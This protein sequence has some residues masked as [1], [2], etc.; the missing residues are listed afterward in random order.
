MTRVKSRLN[1]LFSGILILVQSNQSKS[2][3]AWGNRF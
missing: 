3:R 2:E 1:D